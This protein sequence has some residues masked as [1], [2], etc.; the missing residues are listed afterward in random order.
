MLFVSVI[1]F[2]PEFLS[3]SSELE[4]VPYY[5]G[6]KH[7]GELWVY[8]GTPLCN[9]LGN[10]GIMICYELNILFSPGPV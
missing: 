4:F 5:M 8:I 10:T 9:L 2:F 7:T 3:S 6:P 1:G